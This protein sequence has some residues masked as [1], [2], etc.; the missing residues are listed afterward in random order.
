ML[1]FA[2][3]SANSRV[4]ILRPDFEMQYSPRFVEAANAEIEEIT[5]FSERYLNNAR[6]YREGLRA[7]TTLE[8]I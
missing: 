8:A 6:R 7:Q 5:G 2:N 4:I 1:W 3:L